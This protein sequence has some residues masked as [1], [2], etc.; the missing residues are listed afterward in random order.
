MAAELEVGV[1]PLLER[2]GPLLL[3]LCALGARDRVVQVGEWRAA[4]QLECLPQRFG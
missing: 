4:P 3:E 2:R 1:D